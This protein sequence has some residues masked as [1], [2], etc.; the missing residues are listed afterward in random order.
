MRIVICLADILWK[1]IWNASLCFVFIAIFH[2]LSVIPT[3]KLEH[4]QGFV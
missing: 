4:I 3:L 1:T 2:G